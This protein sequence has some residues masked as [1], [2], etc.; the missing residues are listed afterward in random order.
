MH[1]L[2]AGVASCFGS[3][4]LAAHWRKFIMLQLS[5]L[6]RWH[7]GPGEHDDL[8]DGAGTSRVLQLLQDALRV[9]WCRVTKTNKNTV[10]TMVFFA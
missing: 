3:M 5:Q 1:G 10:K 6:S 9:Q 8:W 7:R 2:C 4:V